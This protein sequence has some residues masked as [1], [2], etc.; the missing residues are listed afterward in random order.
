[1][2]LHMDIVQSYLRYAPRTA[3]PAAYDLVLFLETV[4]VFLRLKLRCG[5]IRST[6]A[7][8]CYGFK[9]SAFYMQFLHYILPAEID[10]YHSYI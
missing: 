6:A 5:R 7:S 4:P 3:A 1:M 8:R 2:S 9:V 10:Q